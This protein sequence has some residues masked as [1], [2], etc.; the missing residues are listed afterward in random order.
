MGIGR[1]ESLSRIPQR[2]GTSM[3]LRYYD[4]KPNFGDMLGRIVVERLT[5]MKFAPSE[6]GL[7]VK[8]PALVA[9]GSIISSAKQFDAVWCTGLWKKT[10]VVRKNVFKV[11]AVRGPITATHLR[12]AGIPTPP[13][14]GD[15][16]FFL[17]LLFETH[18]FF[19]ANIL[20]PHMNDKGLEARARSQYSN[21]HIIDIRQDPIK[22]LDAI[23]SAN[24]VVTSSLHVAIVC[25]VYGVPCELHIAPGESEL[26]YC[27]YLLGTGRKFEPGK[28]LP[29]W[30]PRRVILDLY[31]AFLEA[32]D[33]V[34][35]VENIK[36][37][38]D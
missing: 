32:T 23:S 24:F 1:G 34:E 25:D 3:R 14:Y 37:K 31:E 21:L 20:I 2:K 9:L 17:P 33:Y 15:P 5:C 16:L 6:A 35:A 36:T 22:T 19:E 10:Q 7:R 11:F 8:A 27:D 38:G 18:R 30:R 29:A 13:I 12:R 4:S 28:I 26:K